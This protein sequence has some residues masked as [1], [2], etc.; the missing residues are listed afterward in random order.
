MATRPVVTETWTDHRVPVVG[1]IASWFIGV[2]DRP[3]RTDKN[4]EVTLAKLAAAVEV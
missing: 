1:T 2:R 4:M 3:D